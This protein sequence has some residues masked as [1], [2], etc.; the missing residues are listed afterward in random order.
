MHVACSSREVSRAVLC[1][2]EQR[3]AMYVPCVVCVFCSLSLSL[4]LSLRLSPRC[5]PICSPSPSFFSSYS[6]LAFGAAITG[7]ICLPPGAR[8][9]VG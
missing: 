6:P 3:R 5:T 2:V 8:I 7:H 4:S 9:L 1:G